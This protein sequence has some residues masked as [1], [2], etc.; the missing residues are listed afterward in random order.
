MGSAKQ[1]HDMN[2]LK[3]H[4]SCQKHFSVQYLENTVHITNEIDD[5]GDKLC[6][7]I[8]YESYCNF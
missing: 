5:R 2:N 7:T 3:A 4:F 1:W 6:I 8:I